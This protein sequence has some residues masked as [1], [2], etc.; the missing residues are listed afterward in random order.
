MF[1]FYR[2]LIRRISLLISTILFNRFES[3]ALLQ[4]TYIAIPGAGEAGGG[5]GGHGPPNKILDDAFF[6]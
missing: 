6:L 5:K 1:S 3:A 2:Y 4:I